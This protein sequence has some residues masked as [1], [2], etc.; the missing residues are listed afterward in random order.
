[1]SMSKPPEKGIQCLQDLLGRGPGVK[2]STV[3]GL[4]VNR[5]DTES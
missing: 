2:Q 4:G 3:G 1:M 5:E